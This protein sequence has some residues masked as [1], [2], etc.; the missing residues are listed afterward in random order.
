M[1]VV[2][3]GTVAEVGPEAVTTFTAVPPCPEDLWPDG[4]GPGTPHPDSDASDDLPYH[5]PLVDPPDGPNPK[6]PV[7]GPTS[8]SRGTVSVKVQVPP[9]RNKER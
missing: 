3:A 7:S 9:G 8:P 6:H 1:V 4:T 5:T 2:V